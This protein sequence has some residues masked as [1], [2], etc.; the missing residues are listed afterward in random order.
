MLY[1]CRSQSHIS[2]ISI[3]AII[4]VTG[5]AM[6]FTWTVFHLN[7]SSP[8]LTSGF[9][10]KNPL[11][12]SKGKIM[13]LKDVIANR[14]NDL[15]KVGSKTGVTRGSLYLTDSFFRHKN[16]DMVTKSGETLTFF[17]QMEVAVFFQPGDSGA[18][19][20]M[21]LKDNELHCMG[22]AIGYTSYSSCIV[23]PIQPVFEKLGLNPQSFIDFSC[24]RH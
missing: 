15:I 20:F 17:K 11:N 13:T 4:Y 2:F 10:Q 14:R 21:P 8:S 3:K 1:I 6:L 5:K 16:I 9:G 7:P 23:T 22:L 18:L 24:R 19:V 12:F